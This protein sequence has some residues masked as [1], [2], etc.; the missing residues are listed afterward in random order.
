[1]MRGGIGLRDR[2]YSQYDLDATVLLVSL[3]TRVL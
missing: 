2:Y 3:G 1:M